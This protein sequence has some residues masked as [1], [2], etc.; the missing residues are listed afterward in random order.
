MKKKSLVSKS[1]QRTKGGSLSGP[2][3]AEK[4][5]PT[6]SRRL[7]LSLS[8][9]VEEPFSENG[10]RRGTSS[11]RIGCSPERVVTISPLPHQKLTIDGILKEL[12]N[13][14]KLPRW[15]RILDLSLVFL[16]IWIWLPLVTLLAL[17]IKVVSPGPALYRQM[18][19][20][21]HGRRFMIVKFRTMKVN[22]ETRT[23]EDYLEWLMQS[24]SPLTKL[25]AFDSRLI[26]YGRFLRATGL[27][28][29]P[30][31]FNVIRGEMS[32]VGPRPC[33]AVEFERY[34]PWQKARVNAPP[35][36]TGYWQVNGKNKTTFNQM[37]Q[38]DLYY[39]RRMSL[40]LDLQIICKTLPVLACQLLESRLS[41]RSEQKETSAVTTS[42]GSGLNR[43][44]HKV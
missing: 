41:S 5:K 37:V 25:D 38:L 12:W 39:A 20:G 13:P 4:G 15:K 16:S 35:G 34:Q 40:W 27:D 43:P 14:P 10:H 33:T 36:L 6:L 28:E 44:V 9:A 17:L 30:Q 31:I 42:C 32:L 8:A 18:R 29:L 1:G 21:Y 24:E 11:H 22:A 2:G 3:S 23:H 26:P 19:V 7:P